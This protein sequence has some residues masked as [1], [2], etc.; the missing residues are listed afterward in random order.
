MAERIRTAAKIMDEREPAM[1]PAGGRHKGQRRKCGQDV[2]GAS[3]FAQGHEDG[4]EHDEEKEPDGDGWVARWL[5]L[6]GG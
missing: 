5:R 2:A 4:E 6:K 1:Q 3:F